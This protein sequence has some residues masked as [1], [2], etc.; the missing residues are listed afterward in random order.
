M[1]DDLTQPVLSVAGL[2]FGGVS[3]SV[4]IYVVVE[5]MKKTGSVPG[6]FLPILA[7]ALGVALAIISLLTVPGSSGAEVQARLVAGL[8][9][10]VVASGARSQVLAIKSGGRS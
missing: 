2:V 7:D 3:A 5:A 1:T 9:A 8:V 10:G 4:I 6:R